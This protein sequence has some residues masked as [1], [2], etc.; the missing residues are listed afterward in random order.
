MYNKFNDT[1]KGWKKSK[2]AKNA[3]HCAEKVHTCGL[4]ASEYTKYIL[5]NDVNNLIFRLFSTYD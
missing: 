5:E 2:E 4:R 1:L 3:G